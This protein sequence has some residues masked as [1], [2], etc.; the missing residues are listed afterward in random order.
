MTW[1]NS[2]NISTTNLNE[3][4]DSPALARV[5]LLAA[6]GELINVINGLGTTGGALKIET[7]DQFFKKF[8]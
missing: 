1:G 5:D 8:L 2:S 7:D 6:M 3:A 4:T